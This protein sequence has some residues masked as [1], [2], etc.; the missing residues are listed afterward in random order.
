MRSQHVGRR[1][2]F[3]ADF[4][5]AVP[6]L[7]EVNNELTL[8]FN[9]VSCPGTAASYV[10]LGDSYSS[11]EGALQYDPTAGA[12]HQSPNAYPQVLARGE[13]REWRFPRT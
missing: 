8:S 9:A 5:N 7:N 10:A 13:S 11:G 12:C 3:I 2:T 1:V 4:G 6:E